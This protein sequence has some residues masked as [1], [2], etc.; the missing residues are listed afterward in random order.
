MEITPSAL[1]AKD[2]LKCTVTWR[3]MEEGGRSYSGGWTA[4]STLTGTGIATN[5]G[6]G[7]L[8]GNLWL[9]ND[10]IHRLTA[11]G[12]T[13][14]RVDL[15][16]K[17]YKP[18]HYKYYKFFVDDE[19][20]QYILTVISGSAMSGFVWGHCNAMFFSTKDW[21]NEPQEHLES[22]CAQTR[23]GGWWYPYIVVPLTSTAATEVCFGQKP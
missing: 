8:S 17:G 13:V 12:S 19:T 9:G 16:D 6:F 1:M 15:E 22:N 2:S 5:G 23:G 11:S 18:L 3:A 20:N 21:V 4:L 7:S 14:L 10:K